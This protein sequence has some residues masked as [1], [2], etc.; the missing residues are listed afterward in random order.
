MDA[1]NNMQL[2]QVLKILKQL[3]CIFYFL[4]YQDLH[5]KFEDSLSTWM[6]ILVQVLRLKIN[7]SLTQ[8]NDFILFK[9]KGETLKCILLFATKYKD[10]IL[11]IIY[12]FSGEV[13]SMCTITNQDQK[14]DKIVLN[15]LKYFKNLVLWSEL[16]DFFEKNLLNLITTLIIPNLEI[17]SNDLIMFQEEG[18]LFI[19]VFFEQSDLS[20]RKSANIDLL[21]TIAH[22]YNQQVALFIQQQLVAYKEELDKAQ[23]FNQ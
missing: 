19:Q 8:D 18:D 9:C 23:Q 1:A 10:D 2:L 6:N 11:P 4:N 15:S 7:I 14:F 13:W 22:S 16:K 17:S 21:K 5:P 12:D 20:S 3:M